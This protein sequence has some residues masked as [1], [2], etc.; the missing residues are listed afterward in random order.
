MRRKC[1]RAPPRPFKELTM[2]DKT[3]TT[4]FFDPKCQPDRDALGFTF[5]PDLALFT[6]RDGAFDQE[7]LKIA[8][9]ELQEVSIA[10]DNPAML[11][12]YQDE[13]YSLIFWEPTQPD[14]RDWRLV[15]IHDMPVCPE[16][17]FVRPLVR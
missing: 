15:A 17:V 3:N 2:T 14:A 11:K 8:G 7:L 13:V 16:A 1:R 10:E 4:K 5:H 9:F 6:T 12:R